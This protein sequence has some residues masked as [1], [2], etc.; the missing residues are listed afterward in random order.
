[1]SHGIIVAR[2]LTDRYLRLGAARARHRQPSFSAKAVNI[3]R[4]HK[5]QANWQTAQQSVVAH[6]PQKLVW[7]GSSTLG[8][9]TMDTYCDAWHS[10]A[11]DKVGTASSLLGNKLLDQERYSCDNR[12][13][14]LC[15]E[16]VSQDRRRKRDVRS[17]REFANEDEYG[18]HLEETLRQL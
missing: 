9:R 3:R 6:L 1:M 11:P 18:R 15:I 12:F 8:E 16:A 2:Y 17:H 13:V 14:V 10:S 5:G 4:R 7:H